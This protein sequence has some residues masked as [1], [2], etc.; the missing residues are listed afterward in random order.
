MIRREILEQLFATVLTP[1]ITLRDVEDAIR[2]IVRDPIEAERKIGHMYGHAFR[3][4]EAIYDASGGRLMGVLLHQ[5]G[6]QP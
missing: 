2:S 6:V 3:K 4:K 1:S 5:A